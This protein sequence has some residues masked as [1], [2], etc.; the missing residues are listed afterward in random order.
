MTGL[1]DQ[2]FQALLP[3]FEHAFVAYLR[4]RTIAGQPRASRSYSPY[5]NCPLPTM[6]DK[7]L[8]ML[9]YLKQNPIQE[10]QGQLFGMSQSNANKWIHLLQAVL[11]EALA[12]QELL[13]AR[14]ADDLAA[15]L[16]TARMADVPT[17]PFWH[18]G[19]E[20]PIHRP[21]DPEEQQDYY[22][23]KKKCH[24]V[25]NLLVID[26]TCHICFLSDTYEGTVHDKSL[27][28]LAG[29]ALPRGS[30]LHQE[31]GFQGFTLDGITIIQPKKKPRGGEL[32][33]PEKA[34]NRDISSIRV[35]IEHAIGGVKR[36]R[37]VKDKIRL[38]S[39]GIR[40]AVMET[41]CGLHNFRLQYRPWNYAS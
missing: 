25:K 31:R 1:I 39:D 23:G 21:A 19:T 37:M 5:D 27:A 6:A 24:T 9:T 14:T 17:P 20:R 3:P 8:F 10:V 7:L 16:T 28:E 30:C 36:Y 35:L 26:E 2:E 40:D 34:H 4:D 29:Y 41:C 12:H 38:L 32:T 15:M 33:P 18:D 13:P 22:S 11:N